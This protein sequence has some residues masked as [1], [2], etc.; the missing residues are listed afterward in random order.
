MV[1]KFVTAHKAASC[2]HNRPSSSVYYITRRWTIADVKCA[3]SNSCVARVL[4]LRRSTIALTFCLCRIHYATP[5]TAA[6][7]P[8]SVPVSRITRGDWWG[9]RTPPTCPQLLW[10]SPRVVG[11][12]ELASRTAVAIGVVQFRRV[13][14]SEESWR[15]TSDALWEPH[16]FWHHSTDAHQ[17]C[18]DHPP[19]CPHLFASLFILNYPVIILL[20]SGLLCYWHMR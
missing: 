13:A 16:L 3:V 18:R 20:D 14:A 11:R 2:N 15:W 6:A 12:R 19:S 1:L 10:F 7:A 17:R 8:R 5:A 4:Q 9:R